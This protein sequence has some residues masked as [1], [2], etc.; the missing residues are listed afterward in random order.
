MC[1][2]RMSTW[3]WAVRPSAEGDREPNL[4]PGELRLVVERL[5]LASF[6]HQESL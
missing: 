3:E 5:A 1:A 6:D 2:G 4:I